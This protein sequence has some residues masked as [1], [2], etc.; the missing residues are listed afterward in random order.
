METLLDVKERLAAL[1]STLEQQFED[2]EVQ[3][4]ADFNQQQSERQR[5]A[6]DDDG[7]E[8][9]DD[10][11]PIGSGEVAANPVQLLERMR[12]LGVR[13]QQMQDDVRS[14]VHARRDVQ[15]ALVKAEGCAQQLD[16]IVHTLENAD[17]VVEP[18]SDS[19]LHTRP[20]D[21]SPPGGQRP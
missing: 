4:L 11:A 8:A 18:Q 7:E 12:V 10:D 2:R 3:A 15:N 21:S 17:N 9:S 5:R 19:A 1:R 14:I 16:N 13:L 6:E 20:E